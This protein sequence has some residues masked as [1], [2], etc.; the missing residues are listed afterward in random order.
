MKAKAEP[1]VTRAKNSLK[2]QEDTRNPDAPLV[3]GE[4]CGHPDDTRISDIS[5][6]KSVLLKAI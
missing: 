1:R 3:W 5:E 6:N 4:D 2:K